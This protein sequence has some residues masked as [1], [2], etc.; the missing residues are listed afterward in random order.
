[1]RRLEH[2]RDLLTYAG[3][4]ATGAT[5]GLFSVSGFA[6]ELVAEAARSREVVRLFGLHDLYTPN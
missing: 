6:P 1:L 5:L 4:D 2:L 3:H